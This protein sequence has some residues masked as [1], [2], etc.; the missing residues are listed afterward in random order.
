MRGKA[1]L[2]QSEMAT[3]LTRELSRGIPAS[4]VARWESG[5]KLAGS[6]VYRSYIIISGAAL[7]TAI[8]GV[9]PRAVPGQRLAQMEQRLALL[10]RGRGQPPP[11]IVPGTDDLISTDDA[12]TLVGRSRQTIHNWIADGKVRIVRQGRKV[13]V[14]RIDALSEKQRLDGA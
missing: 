2:T 10:E 7:P 14:S 3:A 1:L 12:A 9:D 11:A 4:S 6:D 13:K 8:G 5:H